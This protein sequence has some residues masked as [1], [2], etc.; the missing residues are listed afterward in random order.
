[1]KT[2][3][4]T[5]TGI[6]GATLQM[7]F[8]AWDTAITTLIILI[9]IDYITGVMLAL[10]FHQSK[11]TP[12]GRLES[13]AGFKGLCRK[14]LILLSV[15]IAYRLDLTLNTQYIREAVIIGFIA[16]ETLSI[17]E[18]I[19]LMGIPVPQVIKNAIDILNN[20]KGGGEH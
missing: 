13:R 14:T 17:I 12:T 18:N 10:I 6:I 9:T 1:M 3:L 4:L 20:K 15:L 19:A 7:I 11:K 2:L 16:N 5:T 8:G